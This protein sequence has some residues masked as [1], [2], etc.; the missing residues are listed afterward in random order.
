MKVGWLGRFLG[1]GVG[2]ALLCGLLA[3]A[4]FP[5]STFLDQ[6][7]NTSEAEERLD[8]L[9]T[10]NDAYEARLERLR[11]DAEIERLAR[12][13]YSLVYPGEEAYAVLPAPLPEL[14]LPSLWPF[15]PMRPPEQPEP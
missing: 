1:Y 4:V 11:T 7:A 5:T 14:N 9:R 8:V 15:G 10:Q 6:R 3:F 12:E 2:G 13:Q